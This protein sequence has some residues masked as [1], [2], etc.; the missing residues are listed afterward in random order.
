MSAASSKVRVLITDVA[1][2]AGVSVATVSKALS[3]QG[4]ISDKT[5]ASIL[6]VA[7]EL[8]YQPSRVAQGLQGCRSFSVGLL[9]ADVHGRF[10]LP[11]L[12]GIEERLSQA[13]ISVFLCVAKMGSDL[14]R[15]HLESLLAFG[16]DGL[17]VNGNRTDPRP[18]LFETAPGL[19]V[20][21]AYSQTGNADD[22]VLL[23]DDAGGA[24]LA[25]EHLI[26][27]GCR[28]IAH[29]TGPESFLA[30]QERAAAYRAALPAEQ[31]SIVLHGEWRERWGF[32]AAKKLF[33]ENPQVDGVFC[34]ND[35]IGRGVLQAAREC[36]RSVPRDLAVVAFDNWQILAESGEPPLSSIDLNIKA[37]G[38]SAAER[39]LARIEGREPPVRQYHPC[40]LVVRESSSRLP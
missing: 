26:A 37:L 40:H 9:S 29:I 8:G 31:A 18:P 39:L 13:R 20:L 35:L 2:A 27:Q 4:R 11:L 28:Q 33:A 21:Y 6:A 3:G 34:G 14:E 25:V 36:G 12:A 15:Q 19:P 32:D 16:I 5:R 22:D 17:I 38:R 30:A 1:Q 10:V 24:R 23:P 7:K